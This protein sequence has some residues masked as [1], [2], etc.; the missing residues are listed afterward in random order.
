MYCLCVNV[1]CTTATGC[2]PNCS[3]QIYQLFDS[4]RLTLR[5]GAQ[6]LAVVPVCLESGSTRFSSMYSSLYYGS[7]YRILKKV[8][9]S[10]H[11]VHCTSEF[12]ELS[13]STVTGDSC[14]IK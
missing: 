4:D 10:K 2:Q 3:L 14:S 8:S 11:V 7:M 6:P 12:Y 9:S 13:E 5:Q 1:Y